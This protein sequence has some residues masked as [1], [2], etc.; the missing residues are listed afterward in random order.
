MRDEKDDII[1]QLRKDLAE[2]KDRLGKAHKESVQAQEE[3]KHHRT[4]AAVTKDAGLTMARSF[5][6]LMD[7]TRRGTLQKLKAYGVATEC[8]REVE[9]IFPLRLNVPKSLNPQTQKHQQE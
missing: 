9:Q 2:A 3:A 7:R 5:D 8:I 1:A 6:R 4:V